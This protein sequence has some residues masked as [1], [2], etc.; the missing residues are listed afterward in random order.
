MKRIS[1][2]DSTLRD[3]SYEV[4]FSF[5][6]AETSL[7][8]RKLEEAGVEFIEIGH[9]MAMGASDHPG[10]TKAKQTDEEYLAAARGAVKKSKFGMAFFPGVSKAEHI[11]LAARYGMGFIRIC[12]NVTEVHQ[13]QPYI[14]Q[15]KKQGMLVTANYMKAYALQ[16]ERLAEQVSLSEG[17]GADVVYIVDSAGGMLPRDVGRYFSAIRRV[18]Q[19]KLGFHGHDNLGL[20]VANS[21]TAA[22]LGFEFVDGTLQGLGRSG[23]NAP[24][25]TLVAALARADYNT[26]IDFLRLLEVG[27]TYIQ[28]KLTHRGH[29]RLDVVSGFAGFHSFFM[30]LV[31]KYARQYKIDPATLIIAVSKKERIHLNELLLEKVAKEIKS[32]SPS[33]TRF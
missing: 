9:G 30:P 10:W 28:P 21:L 11:E 6:A 1:V 24:L 2:I 19:I 23:G 12:T 29:R 27:E 33:S 31:L 14:E 22:E 32:L 17:Y 3:G 4:N 16:P 26:G 25:E 5:S 15:A 8:C 13:S 20:A 18:S 7:L